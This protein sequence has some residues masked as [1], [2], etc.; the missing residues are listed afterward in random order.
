MDTVAI[1]M[2]KQMSNKLISLIKLIKLGNTYSKDILSLKIKVFLTD[3]IFFFHIQ[4]HL[5]KFKCRG[6]VHLFQ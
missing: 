2:L 3:Y 6:K 4:V 5:N 1:L